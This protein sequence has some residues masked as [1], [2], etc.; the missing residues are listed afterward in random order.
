MATEDTS[1]LT[2]DQNELNQPPKDPM[3]KISEQLR[4]QRY[5][6]TEEYSNTGLSKVSGEPP[7]RKTWWDWLQLL[8]IPLLIF[9]LGIGFTYI[10]NQT[11]LQIAQANR[12]KDLQIANDQQ[13]EATLQTYLSSMSDLLLTK[14]LRE[15]GVNDEVRRVARTITLDVLHRLDG[16]RRGFVLLFLAESGLIDREKA[17]IPLG[18]LN[19][20]YGADLSGVDLS[21]IYRPDLDQISIAYSILDRANLAGVYLRGSILEGDQLVGADFTGAHLQDADLVLAN[22]TDAKLTGADLTNAGLIV[23]DLTGADLTGAKL[24]GAYL[25]RANLTDANLQ[26]ANYN[27]KMM[28][29]NVYG[30]SETV[31]PTQWPEG[32]DPVSAGASCVDC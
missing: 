15:S 18:T 5:K 13:Q 22:L 10:Q 21:G 32:F 17:I 24:F 9:F 16:K 19:G 8:I 30:T 26:G 7:Q 27:T 1:S 14:H 31:K 11:S 3:E 20:L 6:V 28:Q 25:T 12:N 23:A 29:V 2:S 4:R